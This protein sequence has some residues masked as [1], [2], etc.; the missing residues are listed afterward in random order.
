MGRTRR[1]VVAVAT[2]LLAVSIPLTATPAL[3]QSEETEEAITDI[4]RYAPADPANLPQNVGPSG[5]DHS[6]FEQKVGC[7]QPNTSVPS[8]LQQRPWGQMFLEIE[9]AQ[10]YATGAGQRVAVIDTGVNEHPR[11]AGRVQGAG[12]YV[13]NDGG[14]VDCDGH[15]TIV[16]GIIAAAPDPV[17]G[18]VGV[19]PDSEIISI[20]NVS[21]FYGPPGQQDEESVI[22][23]GDLDTMARAIVL[24]AQAGATVINLS[25][26]ACVESTYSDEVHIAPLRAAINHAI[27]QDIVV[28]AAAGNHNADSAACADPNTP[29]G[30]NNHTFPGIFPEVLTVGSMGQN[31]ALSEFS[32]AGDWVD[33]V[34][35]GEEIISL[36]PAPNA[37]SLASQTASANGDASNIEGTSFA[38]PYVAGVA[39][40]V[41]ERYPNLSAE[42]VIN[43]LQQTAQH[44]GGLNGHSFGVGFGALNPVAALTE[45]LPEEHGVQPPEPTQAMN[46]LPPIPPFDWTPTIVAVSGAGGGLVL[47]LVTLFIVRTVRHTRGEHTAA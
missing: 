41:R 19:A 12:D 36:D 34:A 16:A 31:G 43:R 27:E 23:A 9:Q 47:L 40:L 39:A 1:A 26:T 22:T 7:L 45:V 5:A 25:E 11:L 21:S 28:I 24:A 35:P 32:V 17:T 42:Q 46:D 15:G 3:A 2:G 37:T 44:P 33:I 14:T 38:A 20:R 6:R 10:K 8:D 13:A 30:L 18:F 4:A 29:N